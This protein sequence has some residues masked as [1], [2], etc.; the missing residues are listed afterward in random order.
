MHNIM[1]WAKGM[2]YT[3]LWAGLGVCNTQYYRLGWGYAIHNIMGW[4][5][6]M[7]YTIL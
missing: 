3:I 6:G 5:G 4:A 2:H 7:Q 1:G